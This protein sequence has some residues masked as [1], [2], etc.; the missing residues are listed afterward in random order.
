M[1]K[2]EVGAYLQEAAAFSTWEPPNMRT[3]I[4][5]SVKLPSCRLKTNRD[6]LGYHMYKCERN[7]VKVKGYV[8]TQI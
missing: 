5:M 8:S 7:M 4:A 2:E 3:T 6:L 1:Q